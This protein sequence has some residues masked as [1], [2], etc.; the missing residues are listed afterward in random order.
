MVFVASAA[1]V[2]IV[3]ER[4]CSEGE[5]VGWVAVLDFCFL[6][7]FFLLPFSL[8]SSFCV[9]LLSDVVLLDASVGRESVVVSGGLVAGVVDDNDPDDV[10]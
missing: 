9:V 8:N 7:G 6:V 1:V 4:D 2:G 5:S 3:A 10:C